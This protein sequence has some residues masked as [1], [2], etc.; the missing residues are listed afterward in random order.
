MIDL[1]EGYSTLDPG[2]HI[3]ATASSRPLAITRD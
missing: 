3:S 1:S 2:M